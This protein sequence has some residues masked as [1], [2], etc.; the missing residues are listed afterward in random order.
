MRIEES[1]TIAAPAQTAYDVI[2]DIE[3]WPE[4]TPSAIKCELLTDGPLAAGSRARMAMVG[5][6]VT[7]W[8]VTAAEP[9]RSFTWKTKSRGVKSVA[10]HDVAPDGDG[11]RVTLWLEMSGP[12]VI[13]FRPIIRKRS[14]RNVRQEADGLKAR[15]EG[16]K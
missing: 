2:S 16:R 5:A 1:R 9:G 13:L 3:R 15:A 7:V 4:W 8:E 6:P 10:G 14:I 12:G 11:C